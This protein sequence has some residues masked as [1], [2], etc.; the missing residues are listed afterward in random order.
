MVHSQLHEY[1]NSTNLLSKNPFG[2]RSKCSTATAL[3][4]FADEVLLNMEKVDVCGAVFLDL[5]KAFDT[6]DHGILMSK[7][8]S[9]GVS[10]SALEWF[11]SYLSNQKQRTSC[12]NELSE[13]LPVTFGVPQGSILGPLLFLVYINDL[14]SAIKHSEVSLYAD[15]TVLYCFSKEPHKLESK[16]NEDLYNVALWLKANKLTLNL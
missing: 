2:F 15:D 13:A 8:S 4:G 11:T 1:L 16:L 12:E 5:T 6:V 14:S 10:P 3:S 9:L 7:L